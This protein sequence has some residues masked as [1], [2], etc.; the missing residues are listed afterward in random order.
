M[1]LQ[2]YENSSV[3]NEYQYLYKKGDNIT[4]ENE[5]IVDY[6]NDFLNCKNIHSKQ[7]KFIVIF[8]I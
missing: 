8:L 2:E 6:G 7:Q 3:K 5:S 1:P 4:I